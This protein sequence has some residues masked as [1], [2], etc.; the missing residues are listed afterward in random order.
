MSV[1]ELIVNLLILFGGPWKQE[2][3]PTE[4][5]SPERSGLKGS[6]QPLE[7]SSPLWDRQIDAAQ[8]R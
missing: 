5:E 4:E 2:V 3:P 6:G 8:S 1:L 7:S